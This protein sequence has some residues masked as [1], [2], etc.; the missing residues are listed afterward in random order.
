MAIWPWIVGF[1]NFGQDLEAFPNVKAW[2]ERV[3]ARPAVARGFALGAEL[4]R[5]APALGSK[6]AEEARKVLFGQT[7]AVAGDKKD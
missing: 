5:A 3:K 6:E 2:F 1:A 4:R 7:A